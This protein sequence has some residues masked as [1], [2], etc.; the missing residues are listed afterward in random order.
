MSGSA[1]ESP[2]FSVNVSVNRAALAAYFLRPE[3]LLKDIAGWAAG[4]VLCIAAAAL[5][6][7]LP[8][9]FPE[10]PLF[11]AVCLLSALAM[12]IGA[13]RI[14][15]LSFICGILIDTGTY[16]QLGISSLIC[17]ISSF[18]ARMSYNLTAVFGRQLRC[19]F[20]AFI[21]NAAWSLLRLF[22]FANGMPLATRVS[23]MPSLVLFSSLLAAVSIVPFIVSIYDLILRRTAKGELPCR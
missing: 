2:L 18:I 3:G 13:F 11:P 16:N 1:F 5:Q 14:Y 23:R 12:R 19:I 8:E 21:A 10:L 9:S 20:S 6:N 7:T 4:F 17:I 15:A 22:I